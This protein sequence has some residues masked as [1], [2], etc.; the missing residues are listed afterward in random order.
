MPRLTSTR[1]GS[2]AGNA[3]A[4]SEVGGFPGMVGAMRGTVGHLWDRCQGDCTETSACEAVLPGGAFYLGERLA[5]GS[6]GRDCL[7]REFPLLPALSGA[8]VVRGLISG[9][10][11][12]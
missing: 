8:F 10:G 7:H 6:D 2:V 12:T 5:R 3:G 9:L 1:A 11:S 4:F